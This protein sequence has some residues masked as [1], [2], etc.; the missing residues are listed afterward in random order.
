M[1]IVQRRDIRAPQIEQF[2]LQGNIEQVPIE[3]QQQT[4]STMFASLFPQDALGRAIAE[5]RGGRG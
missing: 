2:E 1:G 3:P 5:R 4:D